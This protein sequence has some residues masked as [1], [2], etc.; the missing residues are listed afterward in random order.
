MGAGAAGEDD[1]T[2]GGVGPTGGGG[3]AAGAGGGS[4]GGVRVHLQ[5]VGGAPILKR[6]KFKIDGRE[7]FAAVRAAA[8][9]SAPPRERERER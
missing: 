7:P 4:G 9:C 1:A 3:A 8:A 6:T 5:A 2:G